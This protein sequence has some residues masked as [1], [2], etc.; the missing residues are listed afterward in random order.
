MD[1]FRVQYNSMVSL[2]VAPFSENF[3]EKMVVRV[4]CHFSNEC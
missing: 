1:F 2:V 3:S 4:S